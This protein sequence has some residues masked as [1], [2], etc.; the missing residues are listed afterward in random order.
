M[1]EV[2][3]KM[4]KKMKKVRKKRLIVGTLPKGGAIFTSRFRSGI[5]LQIQNL[6]NMKRTDFHQMKKGRPPLTL[7]G[8]LTYHSF[9]RL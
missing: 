7:A 4:K 1:L 9:D 6:N 3:N 8:V 2:L 5:G